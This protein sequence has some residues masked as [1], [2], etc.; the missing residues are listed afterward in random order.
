MRELYVGDV[1]RVKR[2]V[3]TPEYFWGQVTHKSVGT[4]VRMPRVGSIAIV[5]FPEARLWTAG[6][7]ELEVITPNT[8][9]NLITLDE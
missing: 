8:E 7:S 6:F 9:V 5:D 3:K 4:I 2:S 1:V